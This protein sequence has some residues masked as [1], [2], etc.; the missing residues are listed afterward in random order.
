M[1]RGRLGIHYRAIIRPLDDRGRES[2]FAANVA[3]NIL[4]QYRRPGPSTLT[5]SL[6]EHKH[7]SDLAGFHPHQLVEAGR[8]AAR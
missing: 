7:S 1:V 6:L 8:V 5:G 3:E 4:A 2:A